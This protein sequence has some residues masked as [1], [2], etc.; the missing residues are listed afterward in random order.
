M[1]KEYGI[2]VT[3]EY[4]IELVAIQVGEGS[5]ENIIEMDVAMMD[6]PCHLNQKGKNYH[7]G[8]VVGVWALAR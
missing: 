4:G 5:D 2:A 1:T 7:V 8:H 6:V 3:K